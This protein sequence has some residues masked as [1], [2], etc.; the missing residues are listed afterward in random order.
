MFDNTRYITCFVVPTM[1]L[2]LQASASESNEV[3]FKRIGECYVCPNYILQYERYGQ[4]KRAFVLFGQVCLFGKGGFRPV[5]GWHVHR[6][7]AE[8]AGP[9]GFVKLPRVAPMDGNSK[10]A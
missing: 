10:E 8:E 2:Y 7:A 1:L 6:K 4:A 9:K 3:W 5:M